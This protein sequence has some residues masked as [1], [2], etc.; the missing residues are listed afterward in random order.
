MNAQPRNP[1]DIRRRATCYEVVATIEGAPPLVLGFT[2]RPSY[3]ALLKMAQ[4]RIADILPHI[5][6]DDRTSYSTARGLT[7]GPRVR[8]HLTG[9]T[10][11]EAAY[12]T[13]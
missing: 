7:L 1:A 2:S 12:S 13:R 3:S 4:R 9:R 11:R 5:G 10:E 6:P 8:I